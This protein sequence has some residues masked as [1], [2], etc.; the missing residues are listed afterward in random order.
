MSKNNIIFLIKLLEQT[1][2]EEQTE[3][4]ISELIDYKNLDFLN[5]CKLNSVKASAA[6]CAY[7][8]GF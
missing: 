5:E 7:I 4:T 2:S 1:I 3:Q 8:S 6:F